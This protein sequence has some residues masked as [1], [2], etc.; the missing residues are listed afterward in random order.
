VNKTPVNSVVKNTIFPVIVLF[1]L[2]FQ[3]RPVLSQASEEHHL[4]SPDKSIQLTVVIGNDLRYSLSVDGKTVMGPS[5]MSL[6]VGG[7]QVLG[8]DARI[9]T[10][11]RR[12]VDQRIEPVVREK[13]SSIAERFNEMRLEFVDKYSVVFRLFDNGMAYRFQTDLGETITIVSEEA[14]FG[15]SAPCS[16]YF[17][18]EESFF[19]HNER[20][21]LYLPLDSISTDRFGSLPM[22]VA[23]DGLKILITET[24][25]EDYPGMWLKGSGGRSL[26][27][28]FPG[29]PLETQQ[30]GDRNV[31]VVASEDFIARTGGVRSFPWRILGIA[32]NDGDLLTNQLTFQ[33]AESLRI[34]DPSWIKPG[35]VAW[36]WWNANNLYGVDFQAGINTETYKYY[37]DFAARYGI[38]YIVLDEGWYVLGNLLQVVPDIDVEEI[39]AYGKERDV[40]II[41]WV[42]W[43]TLDDQ[44]A[45]AFDQFEK[46]GIAGIKV[47]FMQRDDQW[48]VNYYWR[49]AAEA[50]KRKLLVDFHGAYKPAGLRRAYPNVITR[51]GVMGSEHNKWSDHVTT[52]HNVTLPFIRMV[53]GPMDY[54]PGA[55]LNANK[56]N[57]RPIFARPMSMGT[58]AHQM[59]MYVI[60]ESPLQ[61]LADSPSNYLKESECLEFISSIPTV[62]DDTRVLAA[63]VGSYIVMARKNGRNWYIGGMSDEQTREFTLDFEFL[64]EGAFVIEAIADGLNA[65]R[66]ASDY[67]KTVRE[68]SMDASMDIRMAPG[69]GWVA[70]VSP[71]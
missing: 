38:E 10:V 47:D 62:W 40:G 9:A 31:P 16:A 37:I 50:A 48:M 27:A 67:R 8:M 41:L 33:L 45:E 11:A 32:K 15:F 24:A 23:T 6:T 26:S 19:S 35:K 51:E 2:V 42:V 63:S 55:M 59:A 61:M 39:V 20:S 43:K 57:F 52:K 60:Y 70:K 71:Q 5:T 66:Y 65:H 64:D 44:L 7:G 3:V 49:I 25:L 1:S 56:Q 14:V 29:Y 4:A 53:A 30:R 68:I 36:D 58:R 28:V 17:P 46:W 22:L 21:Y 69:G 12:S 18:E 13:F 34:E 54:T